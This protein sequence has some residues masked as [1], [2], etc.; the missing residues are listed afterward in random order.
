MPPGVRNYEVTGWW[1]SPAFRET[2]RAFKAAGYQHSML[3]ALIAY[4]NQKETPP[5]LVMYNWDGSYELQY[6]PADSK[7]P[8]IVCPVASKDVYEMRREAKAMG[9][10]IDPPA[11]A[12]APVVIQLETPVV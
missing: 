10:W 8:A 2:V 5:P 3:D 1:G 4:F 6:L 9:I 12:I 7:Q 11:E